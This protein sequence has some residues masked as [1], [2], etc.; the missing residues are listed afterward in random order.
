MVCR[1]AGV[2]MVRSP[3]KKPSGEKRWKSTAWGY[4]DAPN[5]ALS[6]YA[7]RLLHSGMADAQVSAQLAINL[8]ALGYALIAALVSTICQFPNGHRYRYCG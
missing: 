1:G 3:L 7:G 5:A 4:L 2:L 8:R 6:A